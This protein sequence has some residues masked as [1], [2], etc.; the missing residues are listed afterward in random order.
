MVI[1]QSLL[2]RIEKLSDV[3][4]ELAINLLEMLDANKGQIDI[5]ERL[6]DIIGDYV[7]EETE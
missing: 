4:K 2:L 7:E 1:K 5:E 3:N 6:M